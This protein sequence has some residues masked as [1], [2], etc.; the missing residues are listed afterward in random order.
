MERDLIDNILNEDADRN[1][2]L[3]KQTGANFILMAK[4][5]DNY[6][7]GTEVEKCIQSLLT[8]NERLAAAPHD[9]AR[10]ELLIKI[11]NEQTATIVALYALL[12]HNK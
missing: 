8:L 9:Q 7:A 1:C 2:V 10:V 5:V 11:V 4:V 12:S 3:D 6:P